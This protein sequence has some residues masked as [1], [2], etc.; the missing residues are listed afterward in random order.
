MKLD[1]DLLAISCFELQY[2]TYHVVS[3][4]MHTVTLVHGPTFLVSNGGVADLYHPLYPIIEPL[5]WLLGLVSG[6]TKQGSGR[7]QHKETQQVDRHTIT[8]VMKR[9]AWCDSVQLDG[10]PHKLREFIRI[11]TGVLGVAPDDVVS[12]S[13]WHDIVSAASVVA[14]NAGFDNMIRFQ[15]GVN[16]VFRVACE[17]DT[18]ELGGDAFD[19][20]PEFVDS[21]DTI[22]GDGESEIN[23][24]SLF[25][26]VYGDRGRF[27]FLRGRKD[28]EPGVLKVKIIG[29]TPGSDER[30]G[31]CDP[32][33][34]DL[35]LVWLRGRHHCG[36]R[37]GGKI[38]RGWLAGVRQKG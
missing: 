16:C 25:R 26:D 2:L 11:R 14:L 20:K 34:G 7:G 29:I 18:R 31:L 8:D 28:L 38:R 3:E 33:D 35:Q 37:S 27:D 19:G 36:Q 10:G 15:V 13:P 32:D 12:E 30:K 22:P 24:P 23:R 1:G 21:T 9:Q 5:D 4:R 17:L 6:R